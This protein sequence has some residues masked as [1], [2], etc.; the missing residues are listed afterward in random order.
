[1]THEHTDISSPAERMGAR[2]VRV[3]GALALVTFLVFSVFTQASSAGSTN[4]VVQYGVSLS[5]LPIGK[6]GVSMVINDNDYRISGAARPRGLAGFVSKVE[7]EAA[8]T[9]EISKNALF[10]TSFTYN[11][12]GKRRRNVNVSMSSGRIVAVKISPKKPPSSD[13]V[14]LQKEHLEGVIDPLSAMLVP[15]SKRDQICNRKIPIFDGQQR[16]NVVLRPG[17]RQTY[18]SRK[19]KAI[20]HVC[21]LAYEPI[22][23]HKPHKRSVKY[24]AANKNMQIWF[25]PVGDGTYYMP[26]FGSVATYIGRITFAIRSIESH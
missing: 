16:Y 7:G 9:G 8:A 23:G 5:G 26:V 6:A 10:P 4:F 12:K 19:F 11:Q 15:A 18:A 2:P 24:M 20:A 1:M 21:R 3:C 22:A 25:A 17:G 13:R 14:P